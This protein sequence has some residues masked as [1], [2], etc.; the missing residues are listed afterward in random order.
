MTAF[1][2]QE[3]AG[4]WGAITWELRSVNSR[5]LDV[6]TRLPEDFRVLEPIVRDHVSA[7]VSRGKLDCTL[8]FQPG[9]EQVAHFSVNTEL[10][11][12]LAGALNQIGHQIDQSSTPSAI[13]IMRWPGVIEA[14]APD[15][16]IVAEEVLRVLDTA[17]SEL[18]DTRM[19]EGQKISELLAQ[20]CQEV[21]SI[22]QQIQVE[23]PMMQRLTR[24]RLFSR[25]T[26][27]SDK[28]DNDRLE[29]EMVIFAQK[30]DV[31]EELERLATHVV[32]VRR[33]LA[34]DKP[35]GRRLD[36]LM[37][38]M[39]REAN[40]LGSKAVHAHTTQASVELKVFIEQMREQ[41]QNIE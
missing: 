12:R 37:Q 3:D 2:R 36:F 21:D 18:V 41:I 8:R 15:V 17:L 16:D 26:E 20:R 30:M 31:S 35:V 24:E 39:N 19:R 34:Q 6:N 38:E 1:A 40:T 23:L 14:S 22:V 27:V 29:Q 10:V 28:L 13:D 5:Y 7:R 11:S 33:V 25:L 9:A 32:E 4:A